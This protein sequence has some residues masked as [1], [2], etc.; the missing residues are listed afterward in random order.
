MRSEPRCSETSPRPDD[1]AVLDD[2]SE[3]SAIRNAAIGGRSLSDEDLD[4]LMA[5][6]DALTDPGSIEG[7]LG[8][9]ETVPSGLPVER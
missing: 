8:V 3:Q 1:W 4:A 7:R 9:P 2:P 5:F 6:L